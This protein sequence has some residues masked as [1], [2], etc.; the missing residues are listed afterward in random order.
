MLAFSSASLYHP[1]HKAP[2]HLGKQRSII[3][4]AILS[5]TNVVFFNEQISW[6]PPPPKGLFETVSVPRVKGK[7]KNASYFNMKYPSLLYYIS[8]R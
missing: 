2:F 6:I 5:L 3:H 1:I 7:A 4:S 8:F